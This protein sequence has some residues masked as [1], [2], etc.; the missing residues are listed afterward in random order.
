ML[1][2]DPN[3]PG[4]G[5]ITP[6]ATPPTPPSE[7]PAAELAKW[8]DLARKH[9]ERSKANAEA[10]KELEKLKAQG[11]SE[12]EKAVATAKAE[13]RA[14]A[15]K[16]A[17]SMLVDARVET[18]AAGRGI[19]TA[20]LLEGLDRTRFLAEDGKPDTKAI[21]AWVDRLAPAGNGG[22]PNGGRP[23]TGQGNRGPTSKPSD[24]NSLIRRGAGL[25]S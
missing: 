4:T 16:E 13:A 12:T 1:D 18:A 5:T 11:M 20:A 2:P 6:P 22:T 23:D 25:S 21:Q 19:D 24:M 15:L 7:D 3:A 14:E 10:A 17:G 8:K 9:E